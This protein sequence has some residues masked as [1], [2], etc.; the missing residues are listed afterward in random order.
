VDEFA[1]STVDAAEGGQSR[2]GLQA[3]LDFSHRERLGLG[4]SRGCLC[5]HACKYRKFSGQ[6]YLQSTVLSGYLI[7]EVKSLA[8][9][10]D[11]CRVIGK[12]N[13][14]IAT[15]VNVVLIGSGCGTVVMEADVV[16]CEM[17][18][19]SHRP[20][21]LPGFRGYPCGGLLVKAHG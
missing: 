4:E 8:G 11:D 17:S 1:Q 18:R 6:L 19:P 3:C 14:C 20:R 15:P 13:E 2:A 7:L 9:T 10:T 12:T 21:R 5:S 16:F